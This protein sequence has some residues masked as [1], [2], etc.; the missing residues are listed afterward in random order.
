MIKKHRAE[1]KKLKE[2]AEMYS[3]SISLIHKIINEK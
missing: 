2:L 3:C 1:V